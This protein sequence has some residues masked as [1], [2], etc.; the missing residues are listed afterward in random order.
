METLGCIYISDYVY[1][2]EIKKATTEG[3][4]IEKLKNSKKIRILEHNK[5]TDIQKKVYL[6]TYKLLKNENPVNERERITASFAKACN[7]YYYMSDD[8]RAASHKD[9]WLQLTLQII[10]IYYSCIFLYLES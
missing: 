4:K 9:N 2:H 7:I 1:E 3:R 6:E 5:L 10:V 8:N